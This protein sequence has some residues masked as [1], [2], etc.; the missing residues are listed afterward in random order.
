MQALWYPFINQVILQR[1]TYLWSGGFNFCNDKG[2]EVTNSSGP[3]A[4]HGN[5]HRV[6]KKQLDV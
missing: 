6:A 3:F 1:F 2:T 4:P 5:T